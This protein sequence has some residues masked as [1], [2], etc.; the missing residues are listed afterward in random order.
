[1]AVAQPCIHPG[2]LELFIATRQQLH[3]IALRRGGRF[4]EGTELVWPHGR[5]KR[6][7]PP[8]RARRGVRR[9]HWTTRREVPQLGPAVG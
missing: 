7:G 8:R 2:A 6:A 5:A 4:P 3:G 1:M 9:R